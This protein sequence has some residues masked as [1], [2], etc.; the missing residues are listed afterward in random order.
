MSEHVMANCSR[1]SF[2]MKSDV[3][4]TPFWIEPD[5]LPPAVMA[6]RNSISTAAMATCRGGRGRELLT[7]ACAARVRAL[8]LERHE[9]AHRVR[10]V[11]GARRGR[12]SALVDGTALLTCCMV[13]T[14]ALTEVEKELAT[15]F[16]PMPKASKRLREVGGEC[17]GTGAGR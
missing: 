6:P 8:V 9:R 12:A 15:S 2:F 17:E 10:M 3:L 5:T 7:R 13:H 11:A 1:P 4:M 16:A 14:P